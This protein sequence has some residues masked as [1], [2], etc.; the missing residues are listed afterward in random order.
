MPA[1]S[2]MSAK[3]LPVSALASMSKE[4]TSSNVTAA[5]A[6]MANQL[7]LARRYSSSVNR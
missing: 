6:K 2:N 1:M 3:I 4:R 7:S 5:L